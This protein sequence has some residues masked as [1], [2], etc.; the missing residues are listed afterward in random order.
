MRR[1]LYSRTYVE[2]SPGPLSRKQKHLII[3]PKIR[4]LFKNQQ[5]EAVL[6][7]IEKAAWQS[8]EKVSSG[9][10]EIFKAAKFRELV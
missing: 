10:L 3:G 8:F 6:S 5:F 4:Q 2:N 7:D 1:F 9:F